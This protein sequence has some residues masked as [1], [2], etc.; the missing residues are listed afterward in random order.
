MADEYELTDDQKAVI[1]SE[2][3][4][5]A[6]PGEFN[7][8]FDD[9]RCLLNNDDLL[10][11][12][13]TAA[14]S[15]YDKEQFHTVELPDGSKAL[16][17]KYGD[18]GGDKF[19]D[20]RGKQS[21]TFDHLKKTV[22]NIESIT[23]NNDVEDKRANTQS[24]VDEYIAGFYPNGNSVVYGLDNGSIVVCIEGHTYNSENFWSGCWKSEYVWSSDGDVTGSIKIQ[25]HYYEDGNIQLNN[26]KDVNFGN[27]SNE[28]SLIARI[29]ETEA[30][31][32]NGLN[33]SYANMSSETFKTL[34][35]A[36][37]ITKCKV[38]WGKIANY[39]LGKELNN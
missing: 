21:F 19:L 11:T 28:N 20:P 32:Q 39:N 16:I 8:V 38:D 25:V 18:L 17:T 29:K 13:C 7:E 6:P 14:F 5:N 24:A 30:N 37:P 33:T 4:L 3:L 36:L 26:S 10:K 12:K 2:F 34:R 15:Q 9:V 31:L 23:I 27:I 35:R 1:A 22:S